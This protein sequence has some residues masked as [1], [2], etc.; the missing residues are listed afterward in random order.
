MPAVKV[1]AFSG[2]LVDFLQMN[3]IS[4]IIRGLRA[5]SDYDYE[6][7]MA[8]LN[9]KLNPQIETL[10]MTSKEEYSYISSTMVRQIAPL[11]GDVSMLVH[12]VIVEALSKKLVK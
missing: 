7:Q 9:R 5:I 11:G 6:A 8:L 4:V 10:F 12:P 1:S 2:L 3:Q